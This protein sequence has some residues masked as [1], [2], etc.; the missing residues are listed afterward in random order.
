MRYFFSGPSFLGIRPGII[1][2]AAELTR[3]FR[4]S[5]KTTSAQNNASFIYVIEGESGKHKIGISS[6]P[7]RRISELQTGSPVALKF[8]FIA[9]TDGIDSAAQIES[10][11]HDLLQNYSTSGEWFR[12]PA[13]VAIGAVFEGSIQLGRSI[14]QVKPE[15]VPHVIA[16]SQSEP[17]QDP[18][19]DRHP[20]VFWF[21]GVSLIWSALYGIYLY[22]LAH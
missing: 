1:F 15:T 18:W 22:K 3:F 2:R 7:I 6:D 13:S 14:Q 10:I 21:V 5:P 20:F 4:S 9:V 19:I 12:I 8:S 17:R 11:A 16:L